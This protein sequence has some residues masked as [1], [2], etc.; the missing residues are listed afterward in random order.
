MTG[1]VEYTVTGLVDELACAQLYGI[2]KGAASGVQASEGVFRRAQAS[3]GGKEWDSARVTG[4]VVFLDEIGDLSPLLQAK[5]LPVLSGGQ[6]YRVGGDGDPTHARS[7]DGIVISATWRPLDA[8]LRQDL[9]SRLTAHVITVPSLSERIDDLPKIVESAYDFVVERYRKRLDDMKLDPDF[10]RAFWRDD[11]SEICPATE[12]EL[13]QLKAV[14]WS[15][16]GDMRGLIT[17][18]ERIVIGREAAESVVRQLQRVDSLPTDSRDDG[19]RLLSRVLA[20]KADGESVI[21]HVGEIEL[22]DRQALRTLLKTDVGARVRTAS[23]FGI[24]ETTLMSGLRQLDRSR[25]KL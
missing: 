23:H 6:Y 9:L 20:R 8:V 14:D 7:F 13:A 24:S 17:A 19:N 15:R 21:L 11:E 2:K 12:E 1:Y 10:D 18:L 3:D 16:H 5:L 22:A 4:G 25:R